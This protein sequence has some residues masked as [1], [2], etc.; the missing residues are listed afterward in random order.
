M[1]I[2]S[3]IAL[4]TINETLV[5]Q[6]I[7]FLI[8]LF[9][10]NR[11][12]FRPLQRTAIERNRYVKEILQEIDDAEKDSERYKQEIERKRSAAR[13]KAFAIIK[14]L[15]DA[16]GME[17]EKIVAAAVQDISTLREQ[18]NKEIETQ[19]SEAEKNLKKE[20][21]ALSIHIME[22]VLDRRLSHEAVQ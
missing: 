4:I 2:I 3:N 6:V 22:K 18:A 15:E 14:E 13:E 1:Q 19:I 12:M 8:L 21:E 9:V 17:A 16:G 11:I 10:L 5:I 20:S 7:S